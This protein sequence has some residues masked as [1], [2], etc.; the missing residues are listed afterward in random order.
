MNAAPPAETGNNIASI[1]WMQPFQIEKNKKNKPERL[2]FVLVHQ[3]CQQ[4][5]KLTV[6]HIESSASTILH[7]F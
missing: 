5:L 4:M 1:T 7:D 6:I 2:L 3:R